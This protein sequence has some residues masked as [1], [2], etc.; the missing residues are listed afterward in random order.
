MSLTLESL[1]RV[2]AI[3]KDT[4][5]IKRSEGFITQT[6]FNKLSY[7]EKVRNKKAVVLDNFKWV[8]YSPST[9]LTF[10]YDGTYVGKLTSKGKQLCLQDFVDN[11]LATI[12]FITLIRKDDKQMSELGNL[13]NLDI[14]SIVNQIGVE[15][16]AGA[17]GGVAPMQAFA[18][19][20]TPTPEASIKNFISS[21]IEGVSLADTTDLSIFNRQH[22]ELVGYITANDKAVKFTTKTVVK[23]ETDGKKALI[24]NASP[25]IRSEHAR[26]NRV[27]AEYYEKETILEPKE[28]APGKVLGSVIGIP[29]GGLVPFSE[30]RNSDVVKFDSNDKTVKYAVYDK[31]QTNNML[32]FYFNSKIREAASTHGGAAGLL[33]LKMVP[34]IKRDKED[35]SE[36]LYV[37]PK[38]VAE[39]RKSV[40]IDTNYFPVKVYDT[41]QVSG[42]ITPEQAKVLNESAFINL[43][44][45][46][47]T[48]ENTTPKINKLSSRF[49]SRIR[50]ENDQIVSSYFTQNVAEREAISVGA[51]HNKEEK[52]TVIEIP[53][54]KAHPKKEGTGEVWRFETFDSLS[55]KAEEDAAYAAK[56]SLKNGKFDHFIAAC[57]G[58]LTVEALKSLTRR[59]ATGKSGAMVVDEKDTKSLLFRSMQSGLQGVKIEG[60]KQRTSYEQF[61][62]LIAGI[63]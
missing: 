18:D 24:A 3:P 58:A 49:A 10:S 30:F 32:S 44:L 36:T 48:K 43:F 42:S 2:G 54:K 19:T 35:Q 26:G 31:D 52:R 14:S 12:K 6:D 34:Q 40:L 51:F 27:A 8:G 60:T 57:H 13:G 15:G 4:R 20:T 39:N 22:G 45:T 38:L 7:E 17:P 21:N 29:A 59:R 62:E 1:K 37:R 5:E 55:K 47:A 41:I 63:R 53:V 23:T 25:E 9:G 56:T 50:K 33:T 11:K 46:P 61:S 28:S 16:G